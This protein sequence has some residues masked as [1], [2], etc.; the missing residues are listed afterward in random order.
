MTHP[1]WL[2][3]LC[4]LGVSVVVGLA[5]IGAAAMAAMVVNWWRE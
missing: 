2:V 5:I 4:A 3:V 1:V